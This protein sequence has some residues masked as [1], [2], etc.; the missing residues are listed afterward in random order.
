MNWI[1]KAVIYVM[2]V[3]MI[4]PASLLSFNIPVKAV[5]AESKIKNQENTQSQPIKLTRIEGKKEIIEKRTEFSKTYVRPDGKKEKVVYSEPINY[6]VV[7]NGQTIWKEI[8]NNLDL[9]QSTSRSASTKEFKNKSNNFGLSISKD[10]QTKAL[11]MT[12]NNSKISLAL[13][14]I[15]NSKSKKSFSLSGLRFQNPTVDTNKL[16]FKNIIDD[17]D[18]IYYSTSVGAKEDIVINKYNGQNTYTFDLKLQNANFV[19]MPDG[20]FK[21]F[22]AITKESLFIMPKF[23]MW[24]SNG[25][26]NN[27]E[28]ELSFNID[29]KINKK[30]SG[31]EIVV[32]ADDKWLSNPRRVFP[33]VIDPSVVTPLKYGI[34]TYVQE[35]YPDYN[36]WVNR[37]MYVGRGATK[38]R[39]RTLL[40]FSLDDLT[41]ARIYSAKA[42]VYQF[43]CSGSCAGSNVS[44]YTT[45]G[46]DPYSVTWN[47]K[48][49]ILS[50]VTSTANGTGN[51]W[52]DFD[53]TSGLK[54][55]FENSNSS[56]SK[57]GSFEFIQDN[58]SDL[59]YRQWVA[60]NHPDSWAQ[61]KKPVIS[62]LYN[63]Y[64][65][66]NWAQDIPTSKVD[67]EYDVPVSVTNFG[68]NVWKTS[69]TKIGY[70]I[71]NSAGQCVV[72]DGILTDLPHDVAPGGGYAD[73]VARVKIP[74]V[75]GDYTIRWDLIQ[76]G[77]TWFS[78]QGIPTYNTSFHV[79]DYPEFAATY[80]PVSVQASSV[81]GSTMTIPINIQNNS[82]YIWSIGQYQVGYHW[83]DNSTND[84]II[85][86]G[87][88][89]N[90]QAD[91]QPRGG[92]GTANMQVKAPLNAGSYTLK[93]DLV[94]PGVAW[95]SDKGVAT[96]DYIIDVTPASFSS[97]TRLGTEDYYTK[98][99]PVDLATGNLSYS[100]TDM[101]VNSNTGLL[102]M[103]RSYNANSLDTSYN[104]DSNGYINNWL[105][106]GPYRE[107]DQSLRL[108][109]K[110][111][112]NEE[113]TRPNEFTSTNGKLWFKA[114][115]DTA[116]SSLPTC[117]PPE[118]PVPMV[119]NL[120]K[121][122]SISLLPK[123]V[124]PSRLIPSPDPTANSQILDI[125]RVFDAAG[126]IQSG[127]ANNSVAY[128][129]VYV[130]SPTDQAV[131]ISV[132]ADDGFKVWLNGQALL[133]DDIYFDCY[134]TEGGL[135][136]NLKSGWN[137]L[138]VKV[139]NYQNN[140]R[141]STRL[142][143]TNGSPISGL[144]YSL[145]N[146]DIF[147][148]YQTLGKGWTASFK[149][150]LYTVDDDNIYYRDGTGSV[151]QFVRN[152]NGTYSRP[153]G[154]SLT[155]VKNADLSYSIQSLS[156]LKINFNATGQL[157]NKTDLSGNRI[158]YLYD[159]NGNCNKI[160]DGGRYLTLSYTGNRLTAVTDQLGNK[161]Q[162]TYD[163]TV[164]PPKLTKVTDSLGNYFSYSYDANSKIIGF[165]NKNGFVTQIGYDLNNKVNSIKDALGNT[166]TL[167]YRVGAVDI[168]DALGR[169]STAEF[170]NN[171][172]L[173]GFTNAKSYREIYIH[174]GNYNV[175]TI[176]PDIPENKNSLYNWYY[177]YDSSDN[178]LT[179]TDPMTRKASYTYSG[180][181]LVKAVD[182]DGST[183]VYT[184]ST[185]GRK[186]LLTEKDPKGN[187]SSYLY[188]SS[189]RKI[190]V[191]DP[192]LNVAKS[193]YSGD[194]DLLTVTSPKNEVSSFT[195]DTIGRKIS[196]KS[197]LG[198]ITT[199]IYNSLGFVTKITDP[200][201]L[202]VTSD[203]D[204]NGNVI[205]TTDPK[206]AIKTYG[207][208]VLGQLIKVTDEVG[209]VIQYVYDAVG[210]KIKTIDANGK[211]TTYSYDE[212]N[213]PIS[214]QDPSGGTASVQYD[215]NGDP[216]KM[217]D[218]KSQTTS[219]VYDRSGLSTKTT[220]SEGSTTVGYDKDGKVTN[221]STTVNAENLNVSYDANNNVTSLQSNINGT[222]S[223]TYNKNDSPVAIQAPNSSMNLSYDAN[224][225][226]SQVSTVQN[227]QT[228]TTKFVKDAEGKLT[229]ATK[230]NGDATLY[231]Y[232][233]SNRVTSI[234]NRN[235]GKL[236]LSQFNYQY[237][238]T[239]NITA[240]K[241][242]KT[243][244]L[245]AYGY[246]ARNQL[247][248]EN[249][250]T[251]AYDPM[252]NRKTVT[253]ATGLITYTYDTA[254]DS[255][256]LLKVTYP[257]GQSIQFQYDA[258]GNITKR[259]DSKTGTT[260]YSY[261]VDDYFTK[262]VLPDGTIV[263][264]KYNKI[265]KLRIQRDETNPGGQTTTTKF[266][267]S[268]DMLVSETDQN[269]K[270]VRLYNW[271][272][273]ER[274]ISVSIPDSTGALQNFTYVK[275]IK[276]DIVG[277]SDKSGN[278]VAEYQYDAW[279][280][281]TKSITTAK[282]S[283]P[284][285]DKLN[286]R[287]YSSYWYDSSL[288]L[289]FMKAR[290]YD[291]Q[292]GRFLSKD[293]ITIG[294]SALGYNPYIYCYNNPVSNI[295]PSGKNPTIAGALTLI[296]GGFAV[297]TAPAWLPWVVAGVGA[298]A[299]VGYTCW[300]LS[301]SQA[302]P[303][304]LTDT[305]TG[306]ITATGGGSSSSNS[307]NDP[308]KDKKN[309]S[310]NYKSKPSPKGNPAENIDPSKYKNLDTS[311]IREI[312]PG[313]RFNDTQTKI[314]NRAQEFQNKGATREQAE[315]LMEEALKNGFKKARID[316]GHIR[317]TNPTTQGPHLQIGPIDH[318]PIIL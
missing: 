297:F 205:K 256:R 162:Y 101:A 133:S 230:P 301:Q 180:N 298:V 137:S 213:Q 12:K 68:R 3:T 252:G 48:P 272:E 6:Q 86:D 102:S 208:D 190:S 241:D 114:I 26:T 77:I 49:E 45:K 64:D 100:S 57:V 84:V 50:W 143:D 132:G 294:G 167:G 192:E 236:L 311:K 98:L 235:V 80:Q 212:L 46:Y 62:I 158:S 262:A 240:I 91:V 315:K 302:V 183:Y 148:D 249:G 96:K 174:D 70:H 37:D 169:K 90:F 88:L 196:D 29:V 243:G 58:E 219:S 18:I 55:W 118:P 274:L 95:F 289:Y 292:I 127:Y 2:M 113:T 285:I 267:Y 214:T 39:A 299:I 136:G 1:K 246:D 231:A 202:I 53:V 305:S 21:F 304:E 318:I 151:N 63:D 85:R 87:L 281:I 138:L 312:R 269:G 24:D 160:S 94:R 242:G 248:K 124:I 110:Y 61:D 251:Y 41:N 264:Y 30:L 259:I 276:E 170:D 59:G 36:M 200:S 105:L 197:P 14:S 191:T 7:D 72:W 126:A 159:A 227:S 280:N 154:T 165:T 155:L 232:D 73:F 163:T 15:K 38:L 255:N 82:R 220:D 71:Y 316:E 303:N 99:G 131:Q 164:L 195:Y 244:T 293:P 121:G 56:G 210:N 187:T 128:S 106:N 273:N 204:K 89:T 42:S 300:L 103:E 166:T 130:Y 237:D 125:N 265:L 129:H 141:F 193:S 186:L 60:E 286:P 185:D 11:E 116:L 5:A 261:D 112:S 161:Y 152:T 52:V 253:D 117:H 275:N 268:G 109:K 306:S 263:S 34:D 65:A 179:A 149:E 245:S 313:E 284:N 221:I 9:V 145:D 4:V 194:G 199:Y 307:N 28:N 198:K 79:D 224:G 287:L 78:D 291:S 23:Y 317:G 123:V 157:Q 171:N 216:T 120:S 296:G 310:K 54:H 295:D 156:G 13:Q 20:S 8:D 17:T 225:Q 217:T 279:G 10:L 175:I 16:T 314:V 270:T 188:D 290:M 142:T 135:T 203:Y 173:I 168:L 93:I 209:A 258:N 67:A 184:Y 239:L 32:T 139:S 250:K 206:G 247:T 189:G 111:I 201:S 238:K 107:N 43:Y 108:S 144:K 234:T 226:V 140:W 66:S 146:Q 254:G 181:D 282:S 283:I 218:A 97:L 288:S 228:L 27:I 81:A 147:G 277:L 134:I 115:A 122:T 19:K 40:P 35:G 25:G 271:D 309:T 211:V 266:V 74:S 177:T 33:I 223:S 92:W 47:N 215:R 153:T 69:N 83:V 278:L 222:V 182:P 257:T 104:L 75:P 150:R 119:S 51:G 178:L 229:S 22:D 44:V 308:G 31:F 207:Y 76:P 172:L 260:L 176:I 233:K